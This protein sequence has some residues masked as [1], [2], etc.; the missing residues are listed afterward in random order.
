MASGLPCIASRIRG[1]TDL[2]ENVE[3]GFL[4]DVEDVSAYAEKINLL[5]NDI[6][7][8]ETMG[9]NNRITVE[10]YRNEN[11]IAEI[12]KIYAAEFGL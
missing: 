10:K 7:M 8:C 4:C 3:G 2:L 11:I 9:E 12:K 5:A 6:V 1:N